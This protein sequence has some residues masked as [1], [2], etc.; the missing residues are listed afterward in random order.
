MYMVLFVIIIIFIIFFAIVLKKRKK[1]IEFAEFKADPFDVVVKDL[2]KDKLKNFGIKVRKHKLVIG[3]NE[4]PYISR[5][6]K[7]KLALPILEYDEQ[8]NI[9][10]TTDK[11]IE[12]EFLIFKAKNK[13]F[14]QRFFGIGSQYYIIDT[15]DK[16]IVYYADKKT[17]NTPDVDFFSYGNIW[18]EHMNSADYI[19]NLAFS[20]LNEDLMTHIINYPNKVVHLEME[21]AKKE[22]TL[23]KTAEI[24]KQKYDEIRKASDVQVS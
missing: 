10:K 5:Y 4:I 22:R 16:N 23:G 14:I 7:K 21:Q 20:K 6:L 12:T 3:Y 9:L 2:I 1:K 18:I 11:K 15:T 19:N 24:E 17:W 13:S 8:K